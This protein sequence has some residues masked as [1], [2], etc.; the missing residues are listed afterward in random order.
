MEG[1]AQFVQGEAVVDLQGEVVQEDGLV[2]FEEEPVLD[3]P[4]CVLFAFSLLVL[5]GYRLVDVLLL[6]F[7]GVPRLH[8]RYFCLLRVVGHLDLLDH[9]LV[10]EVDR[11][12]LGTHVEFV[13]RPF[14]G[15][16]H[17][18]VDVVAFLLLLSEQFQAEDVFPADAFFGGVL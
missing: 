4:D 6:A 18:A 2:A 9:L 5:L 10:L 17:A 12:H 16:R 7:I 8:Y 13:L 11:V 3:L 1:D 15:N 14:L